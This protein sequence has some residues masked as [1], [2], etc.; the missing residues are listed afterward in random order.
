MAT[1]SPS[2]TPPSLSIP[3]LTFYPPLHLALCSSLLG[4]PFHSWFSYEESVCSTAYTFFLVVR[5]PAWR[6]PRAS[7]VTSSCGFGCSDAS[8]LGRGQ[9]CGRSRNANRSRSRRGRSRWHRCSRSR[10]W[11]SPRSRAAISMLGA[12]GPRKNICNT[13]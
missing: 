4:V 11:K 7:A 3:H 10:C 5:G 12:K 8:G 13:T 6:L 2:P 1:C 9:H